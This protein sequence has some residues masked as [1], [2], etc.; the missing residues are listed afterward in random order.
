MGGFR[1]F[2][3]LGVRHI[4]VLLLFSCALVNQVLLSGLE[5]VIIMVESETAPNSNYTL[6]E[7][8][9]RT[10]VKG[11]TVSGRN[12]LADAINYTKIIGYFIGGIL[13]VKANPKFTLLFAT[14]A[15]SFIPYIIPT[16]TNNY[17]FNVLYFVRFYQGIFYGII[18][19]TIGIILSKWVPYT[20]LARSMSL[21]ISAPVLGKSIVILLGKFLQTS[22]GGWSSL[23]YIS[24]NVGI[25][26]V[27]A[28]AFF[29]FPDHFKCFYI[30]PAEKF[31]IDKLTYDIHPT[32]KGIKIPWREVIRCK[33]FYGCMLEALFSNWAYDFARSARFFQ[34][35]L[36]N[37]LELSDERAL[38]YIS[39]LPIFFIV[40]QM[41]VG[42]MVDIMHSKERY[43]LIH[44]R[45]TCNSIGL[46]G[47]SICLFFICYIQSAGSGVIFYNLM[48]FTTAFN[49]VG[50][51]LTHFDL[52]P[53]FSGFLIGFTKTMGN[54]PLLFWR[55]FMTS[56][57][58]I[59]VS[60]CVYF[61]QFKFDDKSISDAGERLVL[62]LLLRWSIPTN[63]K[64][65]VYSPS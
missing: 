44:L 56:V 64:F 59:D 51:W 48:L 15:L 62:D 54:I 49:N 50:A 37:Y 7:D 20:E 4:Q 5:A 28:W 18:W 40:E 2:W 35:Y 14:V 12:N 63:W 21:I 30:T 26:W 42:T 9:F 16:M 24:G 61:L 39:L 52:A 38:Y 57:L 13:S 65:H 1:D 53:N 55:M 45:K 17:G 3:G 22:V 29:G 43:P 23:F 36:V 58:M 6:Y 19:P 46:W 47:S 60:H 8:A 34:T 32:Y 27:V 11:S 41:I 33:P 25:L 31:Y 10:I